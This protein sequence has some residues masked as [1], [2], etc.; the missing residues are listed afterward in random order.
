[1]HLGHTRSKATACDKGS[2]YN[3]KIDHLLLEPRKPLPAR[4]LVEREMPKQSVEVGE[5]APPSSSSSPQRSK[6]E[7]KLRKRFLP[8]LPSGTTLEELSEE[9]HREGEGEER[10]EEEEG[11]RFMVF[12]RFS[13]G[14]SDNKRLNLECFFTGLFFVAR[15]A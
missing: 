7:P 5:V 4:V 11:E 6:D 14:K 10:E 15:V 3:N 9:D 1:M 13:L 8:S 2:N 12:L